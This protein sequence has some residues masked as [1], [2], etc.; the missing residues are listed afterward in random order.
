MKK[1]L[2]IVAGAFRRFNEDDGWAIASH[3]ALSILT[4]LFPFLIFVTAIA[5]MFGTKEL[6]DEAAHILLES[7]PEKVATPLAREIHNVLTQTRGG[8]LTVGIVL[9]IYFSTSAVEALR[10]ALTRAYELRE[11][12]AWWLLRLES[13]LY[14]LVGALGLLALAFLVVL[15]PLIWRAVVRF[16]PA[17]ESLRDVVTLYRFGIAAALI[18][19]PLVI[20]HKY[21]PPGQRSW[22]EIAPGVIFTFVFWIAAGEAFGYYLIEFAANY[23][24]T[25]AGLASVMIALFFLYLLGAIFI[26]G[27]ELNAAIGHARARDRAL[28][29]SPGAQTQKSPERP[30]APGS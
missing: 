29:A 3:I 21:L 10:V 2:E 28:P 6:A 15:A 9:A 13:A 30:D 26:Y 19:L 27:A 20:A 8:L 7:W 17:V 5:S 22:R 1:W 12:R 23:V 24:F 18:A 16:A 4:S 14:V 25:Y 11:Q